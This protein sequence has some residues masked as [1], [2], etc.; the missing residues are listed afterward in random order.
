MLGADFIVYVR[1][2]DAV[3]NIILNKGE[4]TIVSIEDWEKESFEKTIYDH[5]KPIIRFFET[6]SYE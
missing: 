6:K 1:I 5:P 4:G 3:F 2:Q